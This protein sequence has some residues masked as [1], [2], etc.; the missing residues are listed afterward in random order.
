MLAGSLSQL[1][2]DLPV[3]DDVPAARLRI[4]PVI[5]GHSLIRG[6]A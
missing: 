5:H 2:L 3:A 4:G 1:T 6:G